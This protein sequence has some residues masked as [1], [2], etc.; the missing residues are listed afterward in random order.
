MSALVEIVFIWTGIHV[1]ARV[2][3]FWMIEIGVRSSSGSK[4]RGQED[5][6]GQADYSRTGTYETQAIW[7]VMK[8]SL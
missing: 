3:G 7:K 6:R 8:K 5:Y 4:S 1:P 2:D